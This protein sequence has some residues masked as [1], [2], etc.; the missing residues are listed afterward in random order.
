MTAGG[1]L[2]LAGLVK[3]YGDAPPVVA[4]VDIAVEPGEFMTVLGP[5]GC[6]KTTILRMVAGLIEPTAGRIAVDGRDVTGLATHLRNMGLVLQNYALFPHMS[7]AGNVAFGLEMRGVPRA[8]RA[9][10][11]AAPPPMVRSRRGSAGRP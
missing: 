6:G 8:E 1:R 7:V 2:T 10:R 9:A 11:A 3:R 4:G 5:S